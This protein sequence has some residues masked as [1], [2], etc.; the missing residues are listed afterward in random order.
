MVIDLRKVQGRLWP[1]TRSCQSS[2]VEVSKSRSV[3]SQSLWPHGL[4][5]PW[6]SPGQNTGVGSLFLLQ[7][8]FPTQGSNPGLPHCRQILYQ[9]NPPLFGT[10]L[11]VVLI[12]IISDRQ[13]MWMLFSWGR[14]LLVRRGGVGNLEPKGAWDKPSVSKDTLR[15]GCNPSRMLENPVET[16]SFIT[17]PGK[18]LVQHMARRP[19]I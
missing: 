16:S 9:L 11:Y 1:E 15:T 6:T 14:C 4:Y 2:V 10:F 5:S 17:A 3:M 8:I 7:R 19:W 18:I 13:A 12:S